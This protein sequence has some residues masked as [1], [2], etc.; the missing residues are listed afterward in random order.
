MKEL[1]AILIGLLVDGACIAAMVMQVHNPATYWDF[2]GGVGYFFQ[3]AS[4]WIGGVFCLMFMTVGLM[5]RDL[6]RPRTDPEQK[7]AEALEKFTN[8]SMIFKQ[9]V[10]VKE[11]VIA[12][13]YAGMGWY[14]LA[15][16]T[17]I[18]LL[19]V[20][21]AWYSCKQLQAA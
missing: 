21:Q 9:W 18:C 2:L 7:A 15:A 17:V 3:A 4:I 13:I 14:W 5:L 6:P 20:K 8:R 11:L 10:T 16:G 12:A 19:L 1:K